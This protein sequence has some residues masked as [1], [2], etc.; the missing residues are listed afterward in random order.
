MNNPNYPPQQPQYQQPPG[1]QQYQQ[2]PGQVQQPTPPYWPN[3]QTPPGQQGGNPQFSNSPGMPVYN[4]PDPAATQGFLD[5]QARQSQ[6]RSSGGGGDFAKF[7]KVPG[8]NGQTKWDASSGV[9]VGYTG[10]VDL[11][12]CG[13]WAQG[14][15]VP[16]VESVTH[17]VKTMTSPKGVVLG[18]TGDGDCAFDKARALAISSPDPSIRDSAQNWGRARKQTIYNVFN[19]SDPSSHYGQDGVMRPFLLGAGP[20]LQAA[21]K[22]LFD[23]RG[24]IGSFTHPTQGGAIRVTKKKTGPHEMNCEWGCIDLTPKQPLPEYFYPGLQNLWNLQDQVK[25]STIEEIQKVIME[26]RWPM[27]DAPYQDGQQQQQQQQAYNPGPQ[28]P[29]GN[30]Y[31]APQAPQGPV[32]GQ[33]PFQSPQALQMPPQAPQ[34]LQMGGGMPAPPPVT[35]DGQGV[36]QGPPAPILMPQPPQAHPGMGQQQMPAPPP[37]QGQQTPPS[38]PAGQPQGQPQ[39]PP[40]P[41]GPGHSGGNAPF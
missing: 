37:S 13:C 26:L 29:Y 34:A 19:L 6:A 5:E 38:P 15:T 20:Q 35:S 1:Q 40:P 28:P 3:N 8:P 7:I 10:H 4:A 23:A 17:F 31:G 21:L 16:F 39:M 22:Q 33:M 32:Q 30:P 36:P 14:V 12:F 18:C 24:G 41:Q 25:P 27:P 2:P 11:Y 9:P